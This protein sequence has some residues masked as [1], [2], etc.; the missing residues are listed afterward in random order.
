MNSEIIKKD[1]TLFET[2]VKKLSSGIKKASV[3]WSD[4]KF[5]ELSETVSNI[6]IQSR[7][8]ITSGEKCSNSLDKFERIASEEY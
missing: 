7:D 3:L 5:A 4:A 2:S 8:V 1:V 6:A